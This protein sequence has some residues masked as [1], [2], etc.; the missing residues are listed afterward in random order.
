[1]EQSDDDISDEDSSDND[2]LAL[3]PCDLPTWLDICSL[4]KEL[5]KCINVCQIGKIL[6]QID[7]IVNTSSDDNG[8]SKNNTIEYFL[9]EVCGEDER[10]LICSVLIPAIASL[11]LNIYKSKPYIGVIKSGAGESEV[12][13]IHPDF[14]AC[15]LANSFLSTTGRT[16]LN[17]NILKL[18]PHAAVTHWKLRCYFNYFH[19]TLQGKTN[20]HISISRESE[21]EKTIEDFSNFSNATLVPFT[22]VTENE[23][24][25]DGV[26][27]LCFYK[28]FSQGILPHSTPLNS[29]FGI[30]NLECIIPFLFVD[31]ISTKESI[32]VSLPR[33]EQLSFCKVP[34]ISRT[35][36]GLKDALQS[37][38]VSMKPCTTHKDN[39]KSA[40]RRPSVPAVT[41]AADSDSEENETKSSSKLSL[42]LSDSCINN[43]TDSELSYNLS[44]KERAGCI[45]GKPVKKTKIKRKD[46]FNE[47]LKAALERGNTPDESDDPS[48]NQPFIKP[49]QIR[50][51]LRRQRSTGFR[52]FNDNV[53]ESEEFFT[54]TE[55]ELSFNPVKSEKLPNMVMKNSSVNPLMRRK[56]LQDKSFDLST[57]SAQVTSP[58]LP[59]SSLQT[60]S[61]NLFSDSSS[62]S[63][64]GLGMPNMDENCMEDLC[65]NLKGCIET[66]EGGLEFRNIELR[67]AAHSLGVRSLS[68][69]FINA[70]GDMDKLSY[71]KAIRQVYSGEDLMEKASMKYSISSPNLNTLNDWSPTIG[72]ISNQFEYKSV[73]AHAVTLSGWRRQLW[74]LLFYIAAS[75]VSCVGE[76]TFRT[77]GQEGL[78]DLADIVDKLRKKNVN[79][80]EL[81]KWICEF[82]SGKEDDLF[83]FL[84]NNLKKVE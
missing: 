34:Q 49:V 25:D 6:A 71:S 2:L 18:D 17:L 29:D 68:E 8:T 37:V 64:E 62:F 21:K 35:E 56:L 36:E 77:L 67:R 31:D 40:L 46:T 12:R 84:N 47:R 11:A 58:S 5:Q 22:V 60:G 55:D 4:L 38:F 9:E 28:D 59:V 42:S 15:M 75:S 65:D 45:R 14:L 53:G 74:P 81:V 20:G 78:E 57:S 43:Q 10:T 41:S 27:R 69:T 80:G 52:A 39:L 76:V 54:A 33:N 61:S 30:K 7:D 48:A 63:S 83:L 13:N 23:D 51:V 73:T 26:L 3:L 79:C 50:R 70:I 82:I 24:I 72:S 1:M 19:K 32:R 16:S 44:E 66:S